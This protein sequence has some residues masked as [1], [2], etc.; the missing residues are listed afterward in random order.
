MFAGVEVWEIVWQMKS[1]QV[2]DAAWYANA[3]TPVSV[4]VAKSAKRTSAPILQTHLR[5]V[6]RHKMREQGITPPSLSRIL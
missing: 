2:V 6:N 5:A 1:V 4:C 3:R